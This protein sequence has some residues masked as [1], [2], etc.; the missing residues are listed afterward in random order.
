MSFLN[1][2]INHSGKLTLTSRTEFESATRL[3]ATC[4]AHKLTAPSPVTLGSHLEL[5]QD[6]RRVI[7]MPA[8]YH[9]T[10][11]PRSRE[12]L[13]PR[14][15]HRMLTLHHKTWWSC[16]DSN[17]MPAIGPPLRTSFKLAFLDQ[18][19]FNP[20]DMKESNLRPSS[21]RRVCYH[22]T[23]AVFFWWTRLE[24]NQIHRGCKAQPLP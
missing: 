6:L 21:G 7:L 19:F 16:R 9:S 4:V 8:S 18:P 14:L 1:S 22:Y 20:Y 17:S 5:N 11:G 23:N 10:L 15:E 24:L 13:N 12:E 2:P 3:R